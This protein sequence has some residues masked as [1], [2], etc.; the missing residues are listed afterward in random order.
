MWSFWGATGGTGCT[1]V[2]VSAS[3]L[4][5]RKRPTLLVDLRDDALTMLG[6]EVAAVGLA[7]WLEAPRPPP[8]ALARLEVPIHE[9]LSVLPF[10]T[11]PSAAPEGDRVTL[12][13]ALL[14]ADERQVVID[15][16][17]GGSWCE[18]LVAAGER[19]TLVARL[20][21]LGVARAP[22]TRRPH[23]IVL[24]REPGRLLRAADLEAAFDAP[25]E[26]SIRWDPAVAAAVDVGSLVRRLPGAL[27]SLSRLLDQW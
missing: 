9:G 18:P 5:A 6:A 12:L 24:I 13:G 14:A 16:G 10:G 1:T 21:Y 8:D 4:A 23:G 26:A 11:P 27:R 2:A 7:Q 20:C 22:T 3:I 19:S 15:I 17:R 25:V